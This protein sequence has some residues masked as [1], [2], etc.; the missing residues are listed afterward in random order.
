MGTN[1][2]EVAKL[3]TDIASQEAGHLLGNTQEML[4]KNIEEMGKG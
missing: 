1:A 2:P 4:R 3:G